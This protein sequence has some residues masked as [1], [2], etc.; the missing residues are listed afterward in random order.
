MNRRSHRSRIRYASFLLAVSL[1][2]LC[3]CERERCSVADSADTASGL[4]A[5]L[6]LNQRINQG[7]GYAANLQTIGY[8][9]WREALIVD[10][11]LNMYE[12]TKDAAWL[13]T[14]VQHA[15][16]VLT[17][18]DD[19]LYDGA[20]VWSTLK[21][22]AEGWAHPEPI[23]IDNAMIAYPF[24]RFS[25]LVKANP[26]L[27]PT[28]L[29]V[30]HWYESKSMETIR[31]FDNQYSVE[32]RLGFYR[33][34]DAEYSR[35]PGEIAPVNWQ[36]AMGKA[37]L[38][39][40]ESTGNPEYSERAVRLAVTIKQELQPAANGSYRWK[41]RVN[42]PSGSPASAED[43]SHGSIDVQ[44]AVMAHDHGLVFDEQDMMR[45]ASTLL[46]N[47]WNGEDWTSSVWGNGDVIPRLK[48]AALLWVDLGRF[49]PDV[50]EQIQSYVDSHP[51]EL[52]SDY[53][54]VQYMW[55]IS[56]LLAISESR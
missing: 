42:E 6:L 23:M 18:R 4:Q 25:A 15:D 54:V 32:G 12:H 24:A 33:T 3:S 27:H 20:P 22:L 26:D 50:A 44:F 1:L 16:L 5:Y 48:Y 7:Q 30:A 56:R 8:L 31:F 35:H 34:A 13:D 53:H 45:F 52:L 17:H 9:S 2:A 37:L 51:P 47:S 43:I 46:L 41:Y 14:F 36:A 21:Y 19:Y 38:A 40:Y 11:Y 29:N 55:A 39:L 28:F 10:S 49:E